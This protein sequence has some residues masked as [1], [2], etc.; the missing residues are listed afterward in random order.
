MI[1]LCIYFGYG[2]RRSSVGRGLRGLEP[3]PVGG[4]TH[5]DDKI[6]DKS[7]MMAAPDD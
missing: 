5:D 2:M 7:V 6:L 4:P 1:G 3:L